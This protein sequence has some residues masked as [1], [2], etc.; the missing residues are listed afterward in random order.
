M[1]VAQIATKKVPGLDHV[2]LAKNGVSHLRKP[3]INLMSHTAWCACNV[4]PI[5]AGQ[6]GTNDCYLYYRKLIHNISSDTLFANMIPWRGNECAQ[7]IA[8]DFGWSF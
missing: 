1:G 2:V 8:S 6:F 4:A 5:C 3:S 7:V